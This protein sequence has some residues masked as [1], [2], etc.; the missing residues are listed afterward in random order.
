MFLNCCVA[1]A[2]P[3]N[4]FYYILKNYAKT[5]RAIDFLVN[6]M[7]NATTSARVLEEHRTAL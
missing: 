7:L 5:M 1:Y 2:S 3:A 4:S 6:G